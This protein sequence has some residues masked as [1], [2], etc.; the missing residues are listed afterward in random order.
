[1]LIKLAPDLPPVWK[2]WSLA[3][4]DLI[5]AANKANQGDEA[6][7]GLL[8]D[9]HQREVLGIYAEAGNAG[10]QRM[11]MDWQTTVKDYQETWRM[12]LANNDLLTKS[13]PD[14]VVVLP[15]LLLAAVSPIFE[16][17]LETQ[18]KLLMLESFES[19]A[20]LDEL[21]SSPK[22][23]VVLAIETFLP[24]LHSS[25]KL[26]ASRY[27]DN[28]KGI[29]TDTETGLQWMRFSLGQ[30]WIDNACIG[31]AEK[32]NWK[33]AQ[34]AAEN[35]NRQDGYAGY[36]DWRV[37][38]KEELVTLVYSSTGLPKTWNDTGDLC[39]GNYEYPTIYQPVFPNTP[40]AWFWSSSSWCSDP[41][42][43]AWG[44][45]FYR[46]NVVALNKVDFFHVRLVR[47]G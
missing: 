16:D 5:A 32:H 27:I 19:P 10:C 13:Q 9:L 36:C 12:A 42:S 23:G 44:V 8:S 29:I 11:Q 33:E 38:T 17:E 2:Q 46:G 35:L 18:I 15:S 34:N 41:C 14:L 28:G 4:A 43:V 37:P 30:K 45:N 26:I 31:E 21:I 1:M 6:C 3:K 47:G 24:K 40:S 22:N 39:K 20:W 7:H 25:S